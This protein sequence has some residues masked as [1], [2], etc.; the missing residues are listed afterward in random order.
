MQACRYLR[1][2]ARSIA[3]KSQLFIN[4]YAKALEVIPR[5]LCDNSGFDATDVLNKLRQKH[6]MKDG[7]GSKFGV[8]VNGGRPTLYQGSLLCIKILHD[9]SLFES[10]S[11]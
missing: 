11:M 7:S 9:S 4:A 10:L 6:A 3:G 1:E 2:H 5:Q 8:N